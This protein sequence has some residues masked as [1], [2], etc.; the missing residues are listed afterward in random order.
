MTGPIAI[1]LVIADLRGAGRGAGAIYAVSTAGS[2]VGVLLTA[3]LIVPM[4]DTSK[5]ISGTALVL[6]IVGAASLALSGKRS[7]LLAVLVPVIASAAPRPSLPAGIVELD[8]AQSLY[9]LVTVLEDKNRLVRLLRADHS[10]IGAQFTPD[11]SAGFSFIHILEAARFVRPSAN[12]VL[13][14]GLGTGSLPSVLSREG[15]SADVVEIDPAVVRFAEKYFSFSTTG[16]VFVEDARTF[17]RRT[18]RRYDLIVHDTF[19]GGTTP[20]HL[21]SLEVVQRIHDLLRPGGVLVLNFAGYLRGPNAE[22][23]WAVARTVR[24]VFPNV[25]VFRD[26]PPNELPDD[27]GNLAFFASDASVDFQIPQ[28]AR[29]ENEVCEKV[30]RSFQQWEVLKQVPDGQVITDDRNPLARLQLP[31]AEEHYRAMNKLLPAEVWLD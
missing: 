22:A 29:F 20:E 30:Q 11:H 1:R 16:T 17:L 18:S 31:S 8:R 3:F 13:V 12:G 10:V 23:S 27:P 4:F 15:I 21:L 5:I 24:A 26:S 25:R 19:T 6:V 14:V 28:S 7:A 9:G 2:L